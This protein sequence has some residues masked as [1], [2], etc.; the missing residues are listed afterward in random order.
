M[1][2]D[3][4]WSEFGRDEFLIILFNLGNLLA[5]IAFAVRGPVLLRALAV[6]G[7]SMQ[8][9]FYAFFGGGPIWDGVFWKVTMASVALIFMIILLRE[10][11]GRNFPPE[12]R[13]LA[14][15][16]D[17]LN[18]GQVEKLLGCGELRS[19]DAKRGILVEGKVPTELFYLI[20]GTATVV[21]QGGSLTVEAGAFLGEIAFVSGGAATADVVIEPGSRYYVW[22]V[23]R[24]KALLA[25]D[26]EIDVVLRGLINH[27]LAHK[28]A[29]S[30]LSKP[31]P[32]PA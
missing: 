11:M 1:F 30:P 20:S 31:V 12:V 15:A 9:F 23:E 26:R 22:P 13:P 24:L 21:K 18:P 25:R 17:L 3:F 7:T 27:D 14:Q 28:V 10:R 6:T 29:A 32:Q 5:V 4:S 19:A 8:A 2:A 16:F